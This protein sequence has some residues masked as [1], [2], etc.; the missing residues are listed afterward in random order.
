MNFNHI[1]LFIQMFPEAFSLGL[2][3]SCQNER[4]VY[5]QG[6]Q[7]M[8][9]KECFLVLLVSRWSFKNKKAKREIKRIQCLQIHLST[10]PPIHPHSH[11]YVPL[12]VNECIFLTYFIGKDYKDL[13]LIVNYLRLMQ[14]FSVNKYISG[15]LGDFCIYATSFGQNEVF[16]ENLEK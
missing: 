3:E 1:E 16:S 4:Q 7:V 11:S 14:G 10:H 5:I 6:D 8:R 13:A 2:P 12:I 15:W 9:Y